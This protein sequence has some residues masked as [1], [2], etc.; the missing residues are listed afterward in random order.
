[1][2]LCAEQKGMFMYINASI[3]I[4]YLYKDTP[5]TGG[6]GGWG[7]VSGEG[8]WGAGRQG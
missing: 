1:M 6:S 2:L 8:N 5:E 3:C 4:D 7:G